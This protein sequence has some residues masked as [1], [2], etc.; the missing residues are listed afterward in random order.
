MKL[1]DQEEDPQSLLIAIQP[2]QSPEQKPYV[3]KATHTLLMDERETDGGVRLM[4]D[5]ERER[6]R[7]GRVPPIAKTNFLKLFFQFVSDF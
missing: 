3:R 6:Y 7:A 2:L 5:H 4:R 1:T